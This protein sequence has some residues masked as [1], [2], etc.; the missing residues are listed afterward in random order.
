MSMSRLLL[1]K[2]VARIQQEGM[3]SELKRSL[4]PWNLVS[5][6]IG[7]IIGAG[8]FVMTGTAAAQHAGPAI[9]LSFVLAGIVCAFTG[10]CYAELASVLPVSGSAYT[11]AYATLGE[12]FAWVMGW[13][14]VLEYGLAASTVAVGWSG[15]VVSFLKDF[16]V[17]IP[18]QLSQPWGMPITLADGSIVK[19]IMNLPALVGILGVTGLLVA[20]VSESA[21]VNN[22]IVAIKVTVVLAF[23]IIGAF[24]VNPDNWTPFIPENT[25]VDGEFGWSGVFRAASIIF[26]AY[27]GFEA[28]STAAAEAKNPQKDMPFGIIGSLIVCTILYM[29]VSAVLTGV[30]PYSALNVPDPMA[31]AVDQIGLGWFSFIIK[32]GAI[33]GLSSVML[34]LVYGQ[35][36]IFYTMSRDGL[37]PQIF[38]KVHPRFHTPY[39][40]TVIVGSLVAMAAALTPIGVLGDLVSLG[41]IAAFAIVCLSVLFLRRTQPDLHRPFRTPF[42]PWIPV[43]GLISCS[44]LVYGMFASE[45]G[46][47]IATFMFWF[48]MIGFVIYFCYGRRFSRLAHGDKPLDGD[49]AF[50]AHEH[51][52]QTD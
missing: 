13:L 1:K 11:Y 20:G 52:P 10:L 29:G 21:R 47:R 46:G 7:C 31:V 26:F 25:G 6:G 2:S 45:S 40:N 18:P 3:Q 50:V 30:V 48:L 33:L 22:I 51:E 14:L 8:I 49:V 15:Y 34:V 43:G 39:L 12:I 28:V 19:G 5:L 36:R 24:Y 38:C 16:G 41:T 23:I 44:V 32:I 9:I 35:T 4:G 42:M 17:F 37:M 27:V